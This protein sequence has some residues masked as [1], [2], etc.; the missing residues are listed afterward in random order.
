MKNSLT[1]PKLELS[2]ALL[3]AR[4]LNVVG[5]NLHIPPNK[6]YCWCDSIITLG[7]IQHSSIKWKVFVSNRVS[8][9]V[10]I[11]SSKHWRYVPTTSNPADHASRG[12]TP[13]ALT[14]CC[15]WWEGPPWLYFSPNGLH[16]QQ[17]CNR[18]HYQRLVRES[19]RSSQ[20]ILPTI[21]GAD[22]LH[23]PKPYEYFLGV[24]SLVTTPNSSQVDVSLWN[25]SVLRR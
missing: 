18:I 19:S 5:D 4:L 2:A 8:Q 11:T 22:F 9:I 24:D 1:I 6:W 10:S 23:S 14:T 12:L 25:I 16:L 7:W 13:A 21:F 20:S 15:L 17:P 3:T